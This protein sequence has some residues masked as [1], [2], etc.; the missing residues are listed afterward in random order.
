[1]FLCRYT[2]RFIFSLLLVNCS[3]NKIELKLNASWAL[4]QLTSGA[5]IME[6][7]DRQVTT[8][9][10][11]QPS[12]HHRLSTNPISWSVTIVGEGLGEVWLHVNRRWQRFMIL[13]LSSADGGMT[14]GLWKL[15]SLDARRPPWYQRLSCPFSRHATRHV[16]RDTD[17]PN[18][19]L[20]ICTQLI[21][22]IIIAFTGAIWDVLQSPHCA[23]NCL[24]HTLKWPGRNCVQITCNTSST[25]HVQHDVLR[26]TW[27]EGT[28]QL[29]SLTE[30]KSHL[31][32]LYFID[33][34]INQLTLVTHRVHFVNIGGAISIQTCAFQ[35][36]LFYL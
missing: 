35:F 4:S 23:A 31:L 12:F 15:S 13:G 6:A 1:M 22:I 9:F 14:V 21:M 2:F 26:A 33:W 29:L 20:V 5:G 10:T 18:I 28:A 32:E 11:V 19:L 7:D 27:Y 3:A 8:V 16:A 36:Y 17:G 25:C 30:L 34:T 24:Q